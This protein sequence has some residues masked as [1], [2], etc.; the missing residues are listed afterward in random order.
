MALNTAY[1]SSNRGIIKVLQI[2]CGLAISVL[3]CGGWTK[4]GCFGW[5]QIGYSTTINSVI[6][7]INVVFFFLNFLDAKFWRLERVYGAI[8]TVLYLIAA[9][10]MVWFLI[11]ETNDY[12][13]PTVIGT[14]LLFV[15]FMLFLWDVKILQGEAWN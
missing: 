8:C 12:R 10:L 2:I 5:G 13:A 4:M 15:Q 1:L 7:I 11:V 6:T 3:F 9:A 14:V